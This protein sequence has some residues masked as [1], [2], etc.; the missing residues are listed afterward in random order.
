MIE[1]NDIEATVLCAQAMRYDPNL[2]I[3]REGEF[4][5]VYERGDWT[6]YDP[7]MYDS[8]CLVLIRRF[9]INIGFSGKTCIAAGVAN[10]IAICRMSDGLNRAV[11]MCVAAMHHAAIANGSVAPISN[12]S[13]D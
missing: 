12:R 8:Q 13:H 5:K 2:E 11:V 3:D 1:P 10:G 6:T 9:R 7:L 4:V